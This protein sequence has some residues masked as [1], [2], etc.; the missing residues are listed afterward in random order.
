MKNMWENDFCYS[1]TGGCVFKIKD[2][3]HQ[4]NIF[5]FFNSLNKV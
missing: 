3:Q 5:R 1:K 4:E 2:D